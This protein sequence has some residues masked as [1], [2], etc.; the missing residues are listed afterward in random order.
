MLNRPLRL[1]V[2]GFLASS[3]IFSGLRFLVPTTSSTALKS[4]TSASSAPPEPSTAA[5]EQDGTSQPSE[6]PKPVEQPTSAPETSQPSENP[7]PVEQPSSSPET[8]QPSESPKPV[9]QPSSSPETSQPSESP[10]PVEQ[11]SSAP[12]TSQPSENPK[13]VE[14]P[15][16]SPETSQPSESPKPVEHKAQKATQPV[17]QL[18]PT[19]LVAQVPPTHRPK[20]VHK[21]HAKHV[22]REL[23]TKGKPQT[24]KA[25]S[26]YSSM[27]AYDKK[28]WT[29]LAMHRRKLPRRG[30][31]QVTFGIG[32]SGQLTYVRVSRSSGN[33]HVDQ[34]AISTVRKSAPFPRPIGSPKDVELFTI[35]IGSR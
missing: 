26:Q 4:A 25:A 7:K 15:S 33:S 6:N 10:K 27:S 35:Q 1:C 28:V 12:E 22:A 32:A 19:P 18:S 14:Q 5:L 31:T 30:T 2:I 9:E 13:P 3:M 17:R 24:S 29:A 11:P 21:D 16:S 23:P 20:T 8:S 34:M